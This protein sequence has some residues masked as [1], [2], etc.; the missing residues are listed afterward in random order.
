MKSFTARP[1]PESDSYRL[2]EPVD[3]VAGASI[4]TVGR[5]MVANGQY[6]P[7]DEIVIDVYPG[8]Y[9]YNGVEHVA[10]HIVGS[11][12]RIRRFVRTSELLGLVDGGAH[13]T[14]YWIALT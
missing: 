12:D 1:A 6:H 13:H 4:K 8:L 14:C 5:W 10:Y 11:K 7:L 3:I 9:E 2:V